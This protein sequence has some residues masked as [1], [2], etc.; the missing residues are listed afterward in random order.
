M[1]N[2]LDVSTHLEQL[3]SKVGTANLL[4]YKGDTSVVDEKHR[5]RDTPEGL[6]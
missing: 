3:D 6:I 1:Q 2:R 5:V 4:V